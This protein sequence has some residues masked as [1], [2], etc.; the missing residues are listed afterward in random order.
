MPFN[1]IASIENH[2]PANLTDYFGEVDVES[3][4]STIS[5]KKKKGKNSSMYDDD[6]TI[7]FY[8][9]VWVSDR[10]IIKY[11]RFIVNKNR[12]KAPDRYYCFVPI[13]RV[14]RKSAAGVGVRRVA[15]VRLHVR[16]DSGRPGGPKLEA[17]RGRVVRGHGGHVR[18]HHLVR[19]RC[20]ARR[21]RA[22]PVTGGHALHGA[23]TR[24]GRLFR[25]RRRH[26]RARQAAARRSPLG[27]QRA[28]RQTGTQWSP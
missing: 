13:G 3:F 15:D 10:R 17:R 26:G 27:T 11:L 21:L 18:R 28:P 2:D 9:S 6:D 20:R 25:H 24:S 8:V 5:L 4:H 1:R 16:S 23:R 19:L 14:R 12:R 22:R 7:P